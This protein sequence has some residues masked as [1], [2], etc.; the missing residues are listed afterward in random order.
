[1]LPTS[2]VMSCRDIV[3]EI[4]LMSDELCRVMYDMSRTTSCQWEWIPLLWIIKPSWRGM[5]LGSSRLGSRYHCCTKLLSG[6]STVQIGILALEGWREAYQPSHKVTRSLWW[7]KAKLKDSGW[8]W[9]NQVNG[10][11][12]FSL[13]IFDA[14]CWGTG[15]VSGL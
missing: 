15:R 8:V 14:A 12:Y 10:M 5:I 1:M 13:Q 3:M 4:G 9:G 2:R 11:W 6:L 7:L